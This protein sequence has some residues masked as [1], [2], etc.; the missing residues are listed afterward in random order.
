MSW[1]QVSV[2]R[3]D[4]PGCP[5]LELCPSLD[6]EPERR[7]HRH[8]FVVAPLPGHVGERHACSAACRDRLAA[9][10]MTYEEHRRATVRIQGQRFRPRKLHWR[11][12][13]DTVA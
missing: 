5:T 6:F 10:W 13:G 9:P 3:C 8:W 7:E 12:P 2:Y 4:A 11:A 1:E